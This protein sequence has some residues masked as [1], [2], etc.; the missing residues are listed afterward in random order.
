MPTDEELWEESARIATVR[1]AALQIERDDY[2]SHANTLRA[3]R[4]SLREL[5]KADPDKNRIA[6]LEDMMRRA[7]SEAMRLCEEHGWETDWP[8]NLDTGDVMEK[9]I[10]RNIPKPMTDHPSPDDLRETC[11]YLRRR[12]NGPI[13]D[14]IEALQQRIVDLRT[15]LGEAL[16]AIY[17]LVPPDKDLSDKIVAILPEEKGGE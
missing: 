7:N 12:D 4:N 15:V 2:K 9:R 8:L 13:A 14:E 1:N 10:G 6:G 16:E 11:A 5:V 3:E 17:C